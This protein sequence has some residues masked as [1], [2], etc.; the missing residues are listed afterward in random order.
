MNRKNV[1]LMMVCLW[2]VAG[3]VVGC[4]PQPEFSPLA[5]SDATPAVSPVATP[6][7]RGGIV[8]GR[9][10]RQS[11]QRPME[12]MVVFL[13]KTT[14]EHAVPAMIYAPPNAQ[15]QAVTNASGEFTI[16][17]VPDGEYVVVLF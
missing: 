15:P 9:L 2:A 11:D 17:Q 14:A 16:T 1:F 8:K 13:E 7:M 10:V 12:T 6:D 3:L 5:T 4:A